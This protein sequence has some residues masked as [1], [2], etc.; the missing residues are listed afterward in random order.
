MARSKELLEEIIGNKIDDLFATACPF[1]AD[2][3]R[4]EIEE[5]K[6]ELEDAPSEDTEGEFIISAEDEF[7]EEANA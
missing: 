7:N 2:E 5:L 1:K 3:L 4:D 6:A